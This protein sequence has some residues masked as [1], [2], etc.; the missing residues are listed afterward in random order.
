MT[1]RFAVD[2]R[3]RTPNKYYPTNPFNHLLCP[4]CICSERNSMDYAVIQSHQFRHT[5]SDTDLRRRRFGRRQQPRSRRELFRCESG[6]PKPAA[7]MFSADTRS[8]PEPRST[9]TRPR[10]PTPQKGIAN[11]VPQGYNYPAGAGI[12]YF[13]FSDEWWNQPGSRTSTR[14]GAERPRRASRTAIG[15]R[16]DPGLFH[17][18]RRRPPEQR[19]G[20]GE[21]WAE[22][23]GCSYAARRHCGR[24]QQGLCGRDSGM[25]GAGLPATGGI[26][27]HVLCS[28][29]DRL[30]TREAGRVHLAPTQPRLG[31]AMA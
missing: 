13:E 22:Y 28:S 2:K 20:L 8:S 3:N 9:K 27:P 11:I 23:P 12:Y 17:R 7:A 30:R 16:T 31:V 29:Q 21:Q 26:P 24:P 5:K 25:I 1:C 14:G 15:I 19:S 10:A 6:K 18:P 4:C